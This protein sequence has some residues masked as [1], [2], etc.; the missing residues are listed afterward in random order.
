MVYNEISF[1]I[2]FV[3]YYHYIITVII[4]FFPLRWAEKRRTRL[5]FH[6]YTCHSRKF[7]RNVNTIILCNVQCTYYY[8]AVTS[9]IIITRIDSRSPLH[10]KIVEQLSSA[11]DSRACAAGWNERGT[12]RYGVL[13]NKRIHFGPVTKL[14]SWISPLIYGH[15]R[16]LSTGHL[17]LMHNIISSWTPRASYRY[18]NVRI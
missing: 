5:F 2:I 10:G 1:R 4:T 16:R 12:D 7:S 8:T 18:S 17:A 14:S 15:T 3:K 9:N 13:C 6:H 11:L